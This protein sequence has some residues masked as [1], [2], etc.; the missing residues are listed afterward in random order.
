M[1]FLLLVKAST[2]SEAGGF[3]GPALQEAM[4]AYNRDLEA[5]GVRVMARGLHP[6]ANGLRLS[7]PGDGSAP[8]VTEGPFTEPESLVAGFFLL[9]VASREEAVAWAMRLPDPMGRGEG[10]AEL[11]QVWE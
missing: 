11:R 7:Y 5:A 3:P 2:F 1:L 8:V 9:D 10:R 6:S 4:S